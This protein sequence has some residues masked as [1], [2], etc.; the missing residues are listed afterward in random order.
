[1]ICRTAEF[2]TLWKTEMEGTLRLFRQLTDNSLAQAVTAGNRTLGRIAWHI[3]T[4]IPEMMGRTGLDLAGV[5]PNAP[6]PSTA[7]DIVLAYEMVSARLLEKVMAEWSDATLAVTDNLYG[8]MWTRG[9]TLTV[10][11]HHQIHHRGQMTILMRQA[12]LKVPGI[13][14][15]S[16]EEWATYNMAEPAV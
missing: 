2:E 5:D 11:L 14:G 15:P 6:I 7:K 16:Q 1:M 4:T 12:G 10:L 9:F 13:Y 3:T 8:E